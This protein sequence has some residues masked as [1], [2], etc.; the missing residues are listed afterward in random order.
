MQTG[1]VNRDS[2]HEKRM[3]ILVHRHWYMYPASARNRMTWIYQGRRRT[4]TQIRAVI[5]SV[6][7]PE[8]N[9]S[10]TP[11]RLGTPCCHCRCVQSSKRGVE[12]WKLGKV[13]KKEYRSCS[14]YFILRCIWSPE[15]CDG[16]IG[17]GHIG[18]CAGRK[19]IARGN[20]RACYTLGPLKGS[21]F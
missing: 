5:A 6:K 12:C 14:R 9:W 7:E 3:N 19:G 10:L 15:K 20:L 11:S 18:V 8:R 21:V 17:W 1:K 13:A 4:V 2:H 16:K